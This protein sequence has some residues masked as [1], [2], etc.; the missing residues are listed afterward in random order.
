MNWGRCPKGP[1]VT[2]FQIQLSE[3][4]VKLSLHECSISLI[5]VRKESNLHPLNIFSLFNVIFL[6]DFF[7]H[8]PPFI[9]IYLSTHVLRGVYTTQGSQS[10][11]SCKCQPWGYGE[12][13][14]CELFSWERCRT[15]LP[16]QCGVPGH[17]GAWDLTSL[18]AKNIGMEWQCYG[19]LVE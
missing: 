15:S 7:T 8:T 19:I 10:S 18:L 14:R 5:S 1:F 11:Q 4:G 13:T 3:G 12:C 17:L 6:S 2:Q 9:H 16:E